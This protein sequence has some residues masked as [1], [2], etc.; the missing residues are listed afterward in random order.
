MVKLWEGCE[1]RAS[2]EGTPELLTGSAFVGLTVSVGLT[3]SH[4][5]T[6]RSC[7][8]AREREGGPAR[9]S[10][11]ELC[12]RARCLHNT[13][14]RCHARVLNP[15]QPG[16]SEPPRG[17]PTASVSVRWMHAAVPVRVTLA[18]HIH[19]H[20]LSSL[21]C[22]TSFYRQRLARLEKTQGGKTTLL[23]PDLP[24]QHRLLKLSCGRTALLPLG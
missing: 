17:G 5:D 22:G 2:A 14:L 18:P 7:V 10:G 13:W 15:L 1:N 9:G 24:P 19:V 20:V 8:S 4:V 23:D 21:R 3:R 6:E 11:E 16:P 12:P